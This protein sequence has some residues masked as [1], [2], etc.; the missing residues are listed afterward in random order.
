MC[1]STSSTCSKPKTSTAVCR[2]LSVSNTPDP[3][4]PAAFGRALAR[5][6]LRDGIAGD[7]AGALAGAVAADFAAG[8]V[9]AKQ[10]AA[11]LIRTGIRDR[12]N[13]VLRRGRAAALAARIRPL[14][15]GP[16]VDVLAGDGSVVAALSDLGVSDLSATERVG[17]YGDS[18]LP[19]HARFRPFTDDIDLDQFGASTAL[20]S[21][22][23]HHE[24]DPGRLL[25]SLARTSISTW[26]VVEN[27]VTPEFTRP[28]HRFADE[29][30]NRCLNEFGLHCVDE[31]RTLAEW[32]HWL[33]AYGSVEVADPAFTVPGIPFPYSTLVV[34]RC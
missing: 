33:A 18:F 5:L 24:P 3:A 6:W 20:L 7:D 10:A 8:G 26:I 32:T 21:T 4:V 17:D 31:H 34:R 15:A 22:V 19:A 2:P 14:L 30:F 25:D 11:L 16:L 27:C 9:G 1:C 28:F 29:F 13:A 23:L 12:W